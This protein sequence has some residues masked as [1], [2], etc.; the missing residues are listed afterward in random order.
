ML[1]TIN[2]WRVCC[3]SYFLLQTDNDHNQN[4]YYDS[5]IHT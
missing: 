2:H 5:L 1:P 3:I 4:L